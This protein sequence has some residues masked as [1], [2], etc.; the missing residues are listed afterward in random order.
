MLILEQVM[1]IEILHQQGYSQRAIARELGLSRNTVKKYLAK[2]GQAKRVRVKA[3]KQ[4]K[5]DAH[6]GYLQSRIQAA[7]PDWIPA[8]VLWEEI[9]AQGY[10]GGISRLRDYLREFKGLTVEPIHRFETAPGKQMQVDWAVFR[11]SHP[12]LSALIATL[13][14]SRMAYV[15]FVDNE[16]LETLLLCL[17]HAFEA[18]GGVPQDILFDNMKT[19]VIERH[20]YGAGVHRFQAG[21]WDF[22]KHYGFKPTLCQPYRAQTKGKVERF[23]RYLRES[24]Y[25]PLRASLAHVNLQV[26]KQTA[27]EKVKHWLAHTANCRLHATLNAQRSPD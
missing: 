19:V 16:R 1:T 23:I 3:V 2:Q 11:R 6:K 13:G 24:F 14:F 26:D 8:T 15:E 20:G 25:V 22:A 5:L 9:K 18:L 4:Q 10:H 21:L 12:R 17:H 7:K 27:N